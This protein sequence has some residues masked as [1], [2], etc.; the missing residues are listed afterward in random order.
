MA[1]DGREVWAKRVERWRESGLTAKE[2]AA[3]VGLNPNTLTH[4]GWRLR[5]DVDRPDRRSQRRRAA[6][7]ALA[8]WVEVSVPAS[9]VL[10]A[11]TEQATT[12]TVAIAVGPQSASWFEVIVGQGRVIRVP[13][14]FDPAALGRLLALVE[15]R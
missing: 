15:A 8:Q 1:R 12:G 11:E 4:W 13:S 14:D 5:G 3:E 10:A 2:Y 9:G 7:P 6:G